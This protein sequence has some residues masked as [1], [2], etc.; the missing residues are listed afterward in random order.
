MFDFQEQENADLIR[1]RSELL[2]NLTS[3]FPKSL[4]VENELQINLWLTAEVYL[5]KITNLKELLGFNFFLGLWGQD[6]SEKKDEDKPLELLV[7]LLNMDTHQRI[8]IHFP[9][10][11]DEQIPTLSDLWSGSFWSE[12]ECWDM[13]GINFQDIPKERLLSPEGTVGYPLKRS[14]SPTPFQLKESTS[15][16]FSPDPRVSRE[17]W[18]KRDIQFFDYF[19]GQGNG[20]VRAVLECDDETIKRGKLEIG[21]LHRG[22]EK[23]AEG[24]NTQQLLPHLN[25]IN[26]NCAAS[27]ELA[28]CKGI[29]DY[30][31]IFVPD[32]AKALRM[33]FT[34]IERIF[35]HLDALGRIV[36]TLD[37][38]P[39][40]DE[41]IEM[42]E[43][44]TFVFKMYS[45]K[46]RAHQ[47]TKLG[48]VISDVP[49]G[50][51]TECLK[52]TSFLEKRTRELSKMIS[53][54]SMWMAMLC[55][56]PLSS[57]QAI[58]W[59]VSGP[60]LRASGVNYDLRKVNP[61]YFYEDVDFD[62]PLGINGQCYDRYLVRVEEIFQSIS[63]VEQ[64]LDNLPLGECF[65]R[66]PS[67]YVPNKE[68]VYKESEALIQHFKI[69][70]QGIILP[71]GS[72]YS[73]VESPNGELGFHVTCEDSSVPYRVK[74]RTPSFFSGQ[75]FSDVIEEGRVEEIP[76]VMNSLNLVMGEIDR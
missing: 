29:E 16:E 51:V 34:E 22:I 28:W 8:I 68:E 31:E 59:G 43:A 23:I 69:F 55:R 48:G 2:E 45:G 49:K 10:D 1:N 70:D 38:K 50:W 12:Q 64:L 67:V 57:T 46:R 17:A 54:S 72:F 30:L 39:F 56:Y 3:M 25:R 5:E 44:I 42:R 9:L 36:N 62:I 37:C 53:N 32:R 47:L 14:F 33:V 65:S 52:L 11:G 61:Y 27:Y 7:Q 6:N 74:M 21:F 35:E 71:T 66:D 4:S 13:F 73:S 20:P 76:L 60:N 18:K 26:F 40:Y 41:T 15:Y 75:C 19:N 63:I 58:G 24:L